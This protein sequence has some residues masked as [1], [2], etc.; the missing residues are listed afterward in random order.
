MYDD[1]KFKQNTSKSLHVVQTEEY[2]FCWPNYVYGA[3]ICMLLIL[4]IGTK[5]EIFVNR[6]NVENYLNTYVN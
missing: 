2:C 4:S 5:I 1:Y 6:V 3:Y